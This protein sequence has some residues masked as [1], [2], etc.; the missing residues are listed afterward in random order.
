[1]ITEHRLEVE[2]KKEKLMRFFGMSQKADVWL[3]K[4]KKS[5]Q[6]PK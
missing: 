3:T 5:I 4:K 1:M 2:R 6:E